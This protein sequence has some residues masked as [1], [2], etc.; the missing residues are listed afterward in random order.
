MTAEIL[1]ACG[2]RAIRL[3]QVA[4]IVPVCAAASRCDRRMIMRAGGKSGQRHEE[5]GSR[6]RYYPHESKAQCVRLFHDG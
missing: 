3:G 2:D 4:G 5:Q 6:N 1:S